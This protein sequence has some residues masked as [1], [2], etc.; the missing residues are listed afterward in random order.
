[1]LER[2]EANRL[3][4]MTERYRITKLLDDLELRSEPRDELLRTMLGSR[5]L[6]ARRARLRR[7]PAAAGPRSAASRSGLRWTSPQTA[8]RPLQLRR[9]AREA[10]LDHLLELRR[11]DPQSPALD[12]HEP[13]RAR[14]G[15]GATRERRLDQPQ[16]QLGRLG[17]GRD[18][19]IAARSTPISR[20]RSS[21]SASPPSPGSGCAAPAVTSSTSS[22]YSAALRSASPQS[23]SPS[24]PSFEVLAESSLPV[25]IEG[26]E[27]VVGPGVAGAAEEGAVEARVANGLGALGGAQGSHPVEARAQLDAAQ[28]LAGVVGG[29]LEGRRP[30]M[31]AP[32][33]ERLRDPHTGPCSPTPIHRIRSPIQR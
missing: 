8:E 17:R 26:D 27:A 21:A 28:V 11:A 2:L 7:R 16:A 19:G 4:Q 5:A 24:G 6:A 33:R 23:I 32:G 20:R 30:R 13:V 18:P 9:G 14:L 3:R 31:A 25:E 15:L 1:M 22:R 29:G 10:E 12:D